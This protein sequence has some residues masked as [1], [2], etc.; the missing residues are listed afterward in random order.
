M[1]SLHGFEGII[2]LGGASVNQ[3]GGLATVIETPGARGVCFGFGFGFRFL[4]FLTRSYLLS[5]LL[6]RQY[7]LP[8]DVLISGLKCHI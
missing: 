8:E 1:A 7:N 6:N 5:Q 2:I 3:D 4:P